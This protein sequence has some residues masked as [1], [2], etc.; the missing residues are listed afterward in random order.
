MWK[1]IAVRV[2]VAI[3]IMVVVAL[4][5]DK[6]KGYK[7]SKPAWKQW[8]CDCALVMLG[9]MAVLLAYKSGVAFGLGF[10][11]FGGCVALYTQR[12]LKVQIH[13]VRVLLFL[14]LGN[15]IGIGF[16]Q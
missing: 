4:F 12:N 13:G 6:R 9:A 14:A 16:M 11:V 7:R 8:S 1:E 3:I 2:A 15:F 5:L 10:L